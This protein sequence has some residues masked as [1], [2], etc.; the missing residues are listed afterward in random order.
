MTLDQ[1]HDIQTL[2]RKTVDSMSRPG[3][4]ADCSLECQV[5]DGKPEC[6]SLSLAFAQM[7]LDTEVTF[8]VVSKKGEQLSKWF[9]QLT[10][11]ASTGMEDADYIF[12][13]K[14]VKKEFF[15][16]VIRRAKVG[17]L[18]E[19]E[20]SAL[21]IVEVDSVTSGEKMT[22]SGPG[23]RT[24][25]HVE[26]SLEIDWIPI[27]EQKNQQYPLGIDFIFVDE[28]DR[29]FCVPRTTNIRQGEV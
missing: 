15:H 13:T 25:H 21:V 22:L 3:T 5:M 8:H 10:Y 24:E 18:H 2:Y 28:K 16:D 9:H 1:V 4:I 12:V 11:A 27:R 7:L 6:F 23:I 17:D 14:E 20:K 29:M 19:P 26:T